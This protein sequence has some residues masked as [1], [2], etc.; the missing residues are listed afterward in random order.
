[1]DKF[2]NFR[3][4]VSRKLSYPLSFYNQNLS[5]TPPTT[6]KNPSN[7]IQPERKKIQTLSN[8]LIQSW[9]NYDPNEFE[10][11]LFR[12]SQ[13]ISV[14]NEFLNNNIDNNNQTLNN[15]RKYVALV[16]VRDIVNG[17]A[18]FSNSKPRQV[19]A[20]SLKP[21]LDQIIAILPSNLV[22]LASNSNSTDSGN[23]S[24]NSLLSNECLEISLA[25]LTNL[26][27]QIGVSWSNK[28]VSIVMEKV[29]AHKKAFELSMNGSDCRDSIL[30]KFILIL[31]ICLT[32]RNSEYIKQFDVIE[33]L[34]FVVFAVWGNLM[35]NA[36]TSENGPGLKCLLIKFLTNVVSQ[37]WK[38]FYMDSVGKWQSACSVKDPKADIQE[39]IKNNNE[40]DGNNNAT[41]PK[42]LH[43]NLMEKILEI[44]GS[45]IFETNQNSDIESYLMVINSLKELNEK[46]N[47]FSKDV[48][49]KHSKEFIS[50]LLKSWQSGYY[51]K[52][53]DD[54][55]SI[56]FMMVNSCLSTFLQDSIPDYL[57][58][59]SG[60]VNDQY[61]KVLHDGLATEK[62]LVDMRVES[63]FRLRMDEFMQD[64]RFYQSL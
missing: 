39:Q 33:V 27:S 43:E 46:R 18:Q 38:S 17:T 44:Y 31:E 52:I 34:N 50:L 8:F 35:K 48:F 7:K 49:L 11:K 2:W 62:N 53:K 9:R 28:L 6:F 54:I 19:V 30:G 58:S 21:I 51:D 22:A 64:V 60:V 15:Q 40:M 57:I 41:N 14:I 29:S 10:Q 45:I 24:N 63:T 47:L 37:R 16:M 12:H 56:L 5:T 36:A 61:K 26:R 25:V 32:C 23:N 59:S 1:M 42:M 55:A 3:L 13:L 20:R 4:P